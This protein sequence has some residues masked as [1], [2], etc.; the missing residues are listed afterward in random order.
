MNR[1][2]DF[3][4][5]AQHGIWR[6]PDNDLPLYKRIV[7]KPLRIVI[8]SVK[9][10][11][12]NKIDIKAS[13]LTYYTL[14]AVVPIMALLLGLAK[15]FGFK[16]MLENLVLEK[17]GNQSIVN[18][19][20]D[21]LE[22]ATDTNLAMYILDFAEKYL[23]KTQEGFILGIG[24]VV[25]IWAV[26]NMLSQIENTF[27]EIWQIK[28]AR[29][30]LRKYTDYFGFVILFPVFFILSAGANLMVSSR[31][32]GFLEYMGLEFAIGTMSSG[33][34]ILVP[35]LLSAIIFFL[36]YIVIPNTRV[37]IL[38]AIISGLIVAFVFQEM[39]DLYI[40]GQTYISKIN[41]V[42]GSF[43]ALPLFLLFLQLAWYIILFGAELSFAIQ[44]HKNFL[45]DSDLKQISPKYKK[46]I[47]LLI[48]D[49]IVDRFKAGEPAITM[50][51]IAQKSNIPDRLVNNIVNNLI[52]VGII[53][54]INMEDP[55]L[56]GMQPAMPTELITTG[57]ILRK[58]DEK[59]TSD[60]IPLNDIDIK[61]YENDLNSRYN[62]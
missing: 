38:P 62:T 31:L 60:F 51:E 55:K 1:I 9:G 13:A 44:H 29:T 10:F 42:Y 12:D 11:L 49:W 23:E 61:E 37:R 48:C 52:S 15:G 50:G 33:I 7:I 26:I 2:K 58:L 40:Y 30:W 20:V 18:T 45:Y 21:T 43:A 14:W 41:A 53:S 4:Q 54:E 25:L 35:F 56:M 57:L 5:F 16:S 32:D 36:F 3:I 22:S 8:L 47:T 28:K 24:I 46:L 17:F 34:A 39:Q 27:N 59:G 19:G 6:I